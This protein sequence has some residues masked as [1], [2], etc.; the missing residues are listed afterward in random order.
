MKNIY[1]K[2]G[3]FAVVLLLSLSNLNAQQFPISNMQVL[4]PGVYNPG[5][6][7]SGELSELAM[8]YQQRM[9]QFTGSKSRSQFL[10]YTHRPTGAKRSFCWGMQV[11]LRGEHTEGLLTIS[12]TACA[13]LIDEPDKK[14]SVGI[15]I[16]IANWT[17]NYTN[18][19][20]TS[21]ED[22][23]LV[24]TPSFVDLDASMGAEFYYRIKAFHISADLVG[25]Q[26]TGNMLSEQNN[27]SPLQLVP[28][29]RAGLSLH[30][31]ATPEFRIGPRFFYRNT[32]NDDE[33]KLRAATADIGLSAELPKK[34]IWFA[35][36]VRIDTTATSFSALTA[37]FGLNLIKA[38]TLK[39]PLAF[40]NNLDMRFGLS[41]PL[42]AQ[43]L[44]PNVELGI[45]WRFGK[46]RIP[47]KDLMHFANPFWQRE[48]WMTEHKVNKL[49]VN[50][51]PGLEGKQEVQGKKVYLT[52][53]FPDN[54][55][56][57]LGNSPEFKMDTLL[58]RIGG[59][60]IG[61]DGLLENIPAE[62][63]QDGLWPSQENVRDPENLEALQKL[64]W[65]QLGSR[66][67]SDEYRV[68][69]AVP[70]LEDYTYQG[71]LGYNT[72][73]DTLLISVVFDGKDTTVVVTGERKITEL[74]LAA[75]KLHSMRKKLEFELQ[76]KYGADYQVRWEESLD[77]KITVDEDVIDDRP[78]IWIRKLRIDT[79]NPH[80]P[81]VQENV[82][83]LKFLR[84]ESRIP[85][86]LQEEN[87][88]LWD[89]D[90]ADSA[91]DEENSLKENE[92]DEEEVQGFKKR[93]NKR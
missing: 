33:T 71:E 87:E 76:V 77:K 5:H 9:L 6:A 24:G 54:S 4:R 40:R 51:P 72:Y 73:G 70:E 17:A 22:P 25:S 86:E 89:V 34:Q 58:R 64:S 15:G 55:A 79:D 63:I 27:P 75:L 61:V 82:I 69:F 88:N 59:E 47:K 43:A 91:A 35:A 52:Y 7:T 23:Y 48:E 10:K 38:D 62:V 53:T 19:R 30:F 18:R 16:G 90:E 60:Y 68:H 29:V 50:G 74:E 3:A 56:M 21:S 46:K 67:K 2:W 66:L 13:K 14:F 44:T 28:H 32:F 45:V 84:D 42:Q 1:F 31:E 20:K 8:D 65:I 37:G 49:D 12:P 57:F 36:A 83:R 26:L 93:R 11:G 85:K 39:D 80:M 41:Y 92:D 78:I 81:D